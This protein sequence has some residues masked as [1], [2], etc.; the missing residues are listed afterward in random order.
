[1]DAWY[2]PTINKISWTTRFKS[3]L[4]ESGQALVTMATY[5]DPNPVRAGLVQHPKEY[6]WCG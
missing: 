4:V 3:V 1:M 2:S 6:R 5:I